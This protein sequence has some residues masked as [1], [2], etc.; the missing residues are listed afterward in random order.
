VVVVGFA[1]AL[2]APEVVWSLVDSG[3]TVVAFARKGRHA[4]LRHSRHVTIHEIAA[5]ENDSVA[6]LAELA[7]FLESRRDALHDHHVLLPLDDVAVWLCSQIPGS[8]G[9]VLAGPRGPCA[10]LALN[11]QRQI[12]AALAAGFNVPATFIVSSAE[13]FSRWPRH[14]PVIIRPAEAVSVHETR[15]RKGRNWICSDEGELKQAQSAW[16]GGALL[17]QPYLEGTGE[18]VFGLAT[19]NGIVAWS[20]HRRLRMMNPHGSGSSSCVSEA[21]PDEV[22]APVAALIQSSGWRGLFMVELL[23]SRDGRLWFVEFNGRAWGSM[24]LARRQSLE[25]PAWTVKLAID[26]TLPV[27]VPAPT[28][29]VV[30][31][32]VGRELMHV[33]FVLRGPQSRA[34][35]NW[36]SVWATLT[37]VFRFHRRGSFYNWRKDDWR[38]FVTD[39]WY[40]IRDQILK[41]N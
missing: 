23:R 34:I 21:V 26:Q 13:E 28:E 17:V 10:E 2:A 29:A 40:T 22:K 25:Y 4:A 5:P 18:G 36:P 30:S 11:K 33:L 14:F 20:A 9:W 27:R 15:L 41:R 19:S 35:R 1:E 8:S 24:A 6:A 16:N 12:E 37:G 32:N 3:F 31:R 39:S 38:V 7:A